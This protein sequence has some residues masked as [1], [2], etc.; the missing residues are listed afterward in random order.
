MAQAKYVPI[1]IQ[2]LITGASLTTS[3]KTIRSIYNE[4]FARLS[5]HPAR[6]IPLN[7][8]VSNVAGVHGPAVH[9]FSRE[10]A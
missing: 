7:H 3:T 5:V 4:L 2:A 10:F 9:A 6:P 8:L 1:P